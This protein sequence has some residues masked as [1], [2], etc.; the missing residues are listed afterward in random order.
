M[1]NQPKE[2][3]RQTIRLRPDEPKVEIGD[4]IPVKEGVIGV[5]IARY[6]LSGDERNEVSYVVELRSDGG[7]K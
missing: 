1:S 3:A 7:E 4:S 5:V 6:T 2:A